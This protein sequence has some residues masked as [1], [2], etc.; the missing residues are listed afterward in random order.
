MEVKKSVAA[1]VSVIEGV[2]EIKH[3]LLFITLFS[4]SVLFTGK[5]YSDVPGGINFQ[6]RLVDKA[7]VPMNRDVTIT[8]RIYDVESGG[9]YLWEER[10]DIVEVRN[11]LDMLVVCL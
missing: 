8:F 3:F 7:G 6:G 10:H 1:K 2:P 4:F 9:R 5:V 11:G